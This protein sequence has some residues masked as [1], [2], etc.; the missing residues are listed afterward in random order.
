MN[1]KSKVLQTQQNK[2][3][4]KYSAGWEGLDR[5]AITGHVTPMALQVLSESTFSSFQRTWIIP[6]L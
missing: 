6:L 3:Y 2:I 4:I 5:K 1:G